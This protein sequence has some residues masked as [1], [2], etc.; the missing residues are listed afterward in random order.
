MAARFD[1]ARARD[2]GQ[3]TG[4]GTPIMVTIPT[5]EPW[6]PLRILALGLDASQ[7]VDADVFLLTDDRPEMLAG[8]PGLS[9]ERDASASSSLLDDLRSDGGM[10]WI[11][12]SM[13]LT[14]LRL[15]ASAGELDYDLAL[16]A[17]PTTLPSL[18]DVGV[19]A[20]EA[21]TL[22]APSGRAAWPLVTGVVA[23]ALTAAV[24]VAFRRRGP[25]LHGDSA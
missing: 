16:S 3:T 24:L 19:D 9:I 12:D 10:E 8:G 20:V 25:R 14:Y 22:G 21:R 17:H 6:V 7:T 18:R 5:D 2:L 4:D 23:A 15:E 13:W 11:P 1:A